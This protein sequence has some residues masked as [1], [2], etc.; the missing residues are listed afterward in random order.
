MIVSISAYFLSKLLK[1]APKYDSNSRL[2]LVKMVGVYGII[3]IAVTLSY[4]QFVITPT[5]LLKVVVFPYMLGMVL[6]ILPLYLFA[7][8][9]EDEADMSILMQLLRGLTFVG[10][11]PYFVYRFIRQEEISSV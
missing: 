7:P 2:N 1:Y 11:W 3:P 6:S 8:V 10:L 5:D 4:I 9:S